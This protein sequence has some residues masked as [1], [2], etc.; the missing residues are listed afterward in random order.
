MTPNQMIQSL[1]LSCGLAISFASHAEPVLEVKEWSLSERALTNG[2]VC[3]ASA[4]DEGA[5]RSEIYHL[6]ITKTK[7]Q[8]N[9]P[10][11]VLLRVEKN[12]RGNTGFNAS[13]DGLTSSI[14]FSEL[15]T[16]EGLQTFWGVPKN[17]SALLAQL[18]AAD[19]R[20]A[21]QGHGGKKDIDFDIKGKGFSDIL[22]EMEK[23]CNQGAS[24]INTE[25]ETAFVNPVPDQIDGTK[26]A[27]DRTAQLRKLYHGAYAQ[28]I[29]LQGT[30]AD[31]AQVLAKY[32]VFIDEL[33]QNRAQ[34]NQIQNVDLPQ[35]RQ[36]LDEARQQ[37]I[38]AKAEIARLTALIPSLETKVKNSQKA[39]DQAQAILAPHVPEYNRITQNLQNAQ[40]NLSQSQNR[41]SQI[42]SRLRSLSQEIYQL[43]SEAETLERNLQNKR[44]E[45]DS[46]IQRLR[47]AEQERAS[48]NVSYERDQILRNHTEYNQ[49]G[50]EARDLDHHLPQID[51][52][53][54]ASQTARDQK[55]Q[56]LNQCRAVAGQDCSAQEAAYN[57]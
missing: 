37:Q 10:V 14:A 24:L 13:I 16:I 48:F 47:I 51:R 23:R 43:Q 41:L 15:G 33:Q 2:T 9:S 6:E 30:R 31:L 57:Q 29:L 3:V 25:F 40:N 19:V 38:D 32:Q 54:I 52:Q 28:L 1:V 7:N 22:A 34:R 11:E 42:E 44:S 46:A 39:Y 20:V 45:R 49:L 56:E 53:V 12:K 4:K 8:A 26:I 17:L 50:Q 55:Q 5:F 36:R 35:S 21:I 18:K 27:I